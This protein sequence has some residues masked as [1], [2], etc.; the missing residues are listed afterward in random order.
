VSFDL[1]QLHKI[2]FMGGAAWRL[3][4]ELQAHADSSAAG[5]PAL[6]A[7]ADFRALWLQDPNRAAEVARETYAARAEAAELA[8]RNP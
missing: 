2:E 5:S 7:L 8:A 1:I 6:Q 3:H 4:S